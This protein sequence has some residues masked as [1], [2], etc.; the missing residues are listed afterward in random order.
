MDTAV[1]VLSIYFHANNNYYF[2]KKVV[3]SLHI[4]NKCIIFVSRN[5]NNNIMKTETM[6]MKDDIITNIIQD[7]GSIENLVILK[8]DDETDR[9]Y[10]DMIYATAHD[11]FMDA[12]ETLGLDELNDEDEAPYDAIRNET[13]DE[14]AEYLMGLCF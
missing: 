11:L 2:L 9:E 10:R 14:I 7:A 13:I 5:K 3:K 8:Q 12:V 4:R 1:M 6:R